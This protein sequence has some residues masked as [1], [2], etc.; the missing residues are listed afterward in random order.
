MKLWE[1]AL[2]KW[3]AKEEYYN[4][5]IFPKSFTRIEWDALPDW[6][7]TK[8]PD[9]P[10]G[11]IGKMKAG[12]CIMSLGNGKFQIFNTAIEGDIEMEDYERKPLKYDIE[13]ETKE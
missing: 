6:S 4:R 2:N 12:I 9:C 8:T 11:T 7:M 5:P 1:N 10:I 13:L 3:Q